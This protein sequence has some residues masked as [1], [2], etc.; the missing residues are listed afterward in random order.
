MTAKRET[1]VCKN[2]RFALTR[3]RLLHLP[4][5]HPSEVAPGEVPHP[6]Y[7]SPCVSLTDG[8][9]CRVRHQMRE[10]SNVAQIVSR[11]FVNGGKIVQ[12]EVRTRRKCVVAQVLHSH[13]IYY[14]RKVVV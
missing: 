10:Y 14:K 4:L 3:R 12:T 2:H 11:A 8:L 9:A 5:E 13:F 1:G 6:H 7:V